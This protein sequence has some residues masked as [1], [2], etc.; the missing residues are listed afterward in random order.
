[1]TKP[2]VNELLSRLCRLTGFRISI[3]D[4][5]GREIAA[6]PQHLHAFCR[7]LQQNPS[8]RCQCEKS[9][10][11]AFQQ[12]SRTGELT[13]YRCA[14]GLYEA[15]YPL[16][17]YGAPAGFLMM[18]QIPEA[19]TGAAEALR[20]AVPYG[21]PD[22]LQKAIEQLPCYT[23][24]KIEAFAEILAVFA[25]YMTLT[26]AVRVWTEDT[27]AEVREYLTTHYAEYITIA[28]LC[29]RFALSRT[30]LLNRYKECYG[31]TVGQTLARVRMT[32]AQKLLTETSLSIAEISSRCGYADPSYFA[33]A[34]RKWF[35]VSPTQERQAHG[36][37][38]SK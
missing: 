29:A 16:Y 11:E 6:C 38:S 2:D 35:G 24:D 15:V 25:E 17:R 20:R 23:R 13:V 34:Y 12:V 5:S 4:G 3:H 36:A 37:Q 22:L 9:D 14:F 10:R 31:E 26:G 8:A 18:G 32:Q 33:K 27:S 28:F 30:T 1:M 21:D 7:C 19:E